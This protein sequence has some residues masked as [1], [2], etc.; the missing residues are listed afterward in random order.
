MQIPHRAKILSVAEM[1]GLE[2]AADA[3]GHSFAAMME[4][5]GEAVAETI[6]EHFVN[7]AA[8]VL[9]LVGPGNNGGDGLV[10]ARHL[11][12]A[13]IYVWQR[14][15]DPA[16]DYEGHYAALVKRGTQI[17]HA[18]DDPDFA[19]LR[20]WLGDCGV[21]V[22]ALLGTGSN[23]PITGQ[24]ADLLDVV[25]DG[26]AHGPYHDYLQG[27]RP[28]V[29]AV[30]CPSGLNCDTGELDPHAI[31]ADVTVTFGHAKHGHFKFP[32]AS[33]IGQ[34][35]VADIGIDPALSEGFAAF[36]LDAAWVAERLPARPAFSHK[37]SYGKVMAAV[38]SINYPGAA[39]L[40]CAA[41][42]R[43][44]AGLVTAAVAQPVWAP[45]ASRLS[46]ATFVL[47]PS[48]MGVI[49]E[50]GAKILRENLPG[51]AALLV[52]CGLT[53]ED[54]ALSF[55][56]ALFGGSQAKARPAGPFAIGGGLTRGALSAADQA[57]PLPATVIDAD[58]LNC[59]A[60]LENWPDLLPKACVLT[61][62][63][64]EMARLCGLEVAEVLADRWG[65][66]RRKATE[67]GAVVLVKGPYTV[68]ADPDGALAVLPVA[69]SALA[70]AGTGDVLAGCIAGLLAQGL[71]PFAS[72]CVGAWLHG[73]A[74]LLCAD[75]IGPAGVL[76][77]DLLARLPAARHV[78]IA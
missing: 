19:I 45:L 50:G 70:S 69:T 52:G 59:L 71:D 62:H 32:G 9:V 60:R 44:G 67:W 53:Q 20:R 25:K 76:A 66:A 38:G 73:Q 37:G 74:G 30:D 3:A 23:R 28:L 12:N 40:S 13:R 51:Y 11:G 22:D 54:P 78:T 57:H 27:K 61:P 10:C 68:I 15:T 1:Q 34:L 56:R 35:V 4:R 29:V 24:L 2:Q 48:D 72:A 41:A 43:V 33:A 5:A 75:E 8:G 58:G 64:A 77:G 55:V 14:A 17:A 26:L 39:Y 31:P 36:V 18:D 21:V 65:L 63:P 47:L 46:E 49:A 7:V 16:Q 42:A 6:H